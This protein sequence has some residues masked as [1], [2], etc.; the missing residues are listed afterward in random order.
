M[1]KISQVLNWLSS[2]KIAILL[3][4]LI[5][6]SC[7]TGTIIPQLESDQFY[8]ENYNKNPFLGIINGNILLLF[9]LNHI[10]TSFWFLLLLIWLAIALAVCSFRRQLP[11]LKSALNWVDYKSPKQIAKLSI[12]QTIQAN[13]TSKSLEEL[14]NFLRER[15][16]NIRETDGRIAAR[17]GV[18]GRVG[19]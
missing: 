15:N 5:A 18:V 11:I 19:P 2:L 9:D 3:L 6:I 4:L 8:L 7:A 16:W 10:F 13:N 12:A 14:T 17:Q 1:K